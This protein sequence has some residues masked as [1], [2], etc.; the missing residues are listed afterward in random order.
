[1]FLLRSFII[2]LNNNHGQ[3]FL[4]EV[5]FCNLWSEKEAGFGFSFKNQNLGRC[6]TNTAGQ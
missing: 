1:M 6:E 4:F 5:E 3:P 2:V